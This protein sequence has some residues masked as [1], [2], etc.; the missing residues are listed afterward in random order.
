[1]NRK[2]L[3]RV[4][5]ILSVIG[6]LLSLYLVKNHYTGITEGSFCDFGEEISCSLVNSSIYSELFNVPVALFG[7]LWFVILYL[8][9]HYGMNKIVH[10]K[11]LVAWSL[12]GTTFIVYMIM[13]EI[14]LRSICPLCTILHIIILTVL[15]ISI[16]INKNTKKSIKKKELIKTYIPWVITIGIIFT[17]PLIAFNI[18]GQN[19]D[20]NEFAICLDEAG[21]KMYGSF[22]CGACAKQRTLFGYAFKNI[23]EI[24]CHP[25]GKNAQTELCLI[26]KIEKTPTWVLEKNGEEITRTSGFTSPEKLAEMSG[27]SLELIK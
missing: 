25:Q 26:K 23:E 15:F 6:I 18:G 22:K 12:I 19:R 11:G 2:T 9:A 14:I 4:V 20:Y 5:K 21:V 24:E 7:A 27:C 16:Y 13:A 8:L 17:I 3:L 10:N 1:M